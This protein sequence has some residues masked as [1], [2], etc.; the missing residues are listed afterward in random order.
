VGSQNPDVT[1]EIESGGSVSLTEKNHQD[2]AG[3][4]PNESLEHSILNRIKQ[5]GLENDPAFM[6]ELI[7]SYEPLFQKQLK[8]IQDAL[9]RKDS[10]KLHYAAHALKGACLNIGAAG[11]AGCC[12]DIE[13]LAEQKNI[14]AIQARIGS[15]DEEV[16]KTVQALHSIKT[17]FSGQKP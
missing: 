11:L 5:L 1:A 16:E 7:D 14:K 10:V 8:N 9:S 15:L 13:E 6:L 3:K 12:K 4:A 17:M 2:H